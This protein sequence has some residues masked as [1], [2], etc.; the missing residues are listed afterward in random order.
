MNGT[1]LKQITIP[2]SGSNAKD[3]FVEDSKRYDAFV[4]IN[5]EEF[6]SSST[7]DRVETQSSTILNKPTV[8]RRMREAIDD[9]SFIKA[10]NALILCEGKEAFGKCDEHLA[11]QPHLEAKNYLKS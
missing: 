9:K 11:T 2:S 10:V 4:D 3:D 7:S 8:I 6:E 1:P 5:Q